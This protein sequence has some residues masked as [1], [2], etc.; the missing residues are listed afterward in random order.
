MQQGGDHPA[1][2]EGYVAK[3]GELPL[4]NGKFYF[5]QRILYLYEMLASHSLM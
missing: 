1:S 5:V 3:R 2:L 4:Q